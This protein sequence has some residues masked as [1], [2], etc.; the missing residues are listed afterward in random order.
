[1]PLFKLRI[2][3]PDVEL[4][5]AASDVIEGLGEPAPLAVTLFELRPPT[6]VV[7]AYYDAAPSAGRRE[8]APGGA[9]RAP[10]GCLA[11]GGA[12]AELGGPVASVA[13][14]DRRRSLHR[15]RQPRP[16]P[17]PPPAPG[18]GDRGRRGLRQRPQRH[19]RPVPGGARRPGAAPRRCLRRVLDLGCGSGVLAIAAA[20]V[21]PAARITRRRQ[22]SR[23]R[24]DRQGERAAQPRQPGAC[25]CS[26]RPASHHPVAAPRRAVRSCAGQHP[27]GAAGRAGAGAAQSDRGAEALPCCPACWTTKRARL[28]PPIA[29][30]AFACC[31]ACSAPAGQR[32]SS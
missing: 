11:G 26:R 19:H 7:E 24:G 30:R 15:A 27:A 28:P 9:R 25:G 32:S 16:R 4:G 13:A 23:R 14:A 8:A 22:R 1:M 20:R 21:A 17:L 10:G 29:P 6:F 18:P 3:V 2:E 31:G 5:R 12:G